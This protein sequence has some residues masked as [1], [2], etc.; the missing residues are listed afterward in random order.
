MQLHGYL[1]SRRMVLSSIFPDPLPKK[2]TRDDHGFFLF[3]FFILF[4]HPLRDGVSTLP[5]LHRSVM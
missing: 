5:F 3:S 1:E 4:R 2:R